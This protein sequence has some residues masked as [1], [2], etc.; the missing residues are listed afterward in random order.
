MN[1]TVGVALEH[2]AALM[3]KAVHPSARSDIDRENMKSVV[4]SSRSSRNRAIT[5]ITRMLNTIFR[6][7]TALI[8]AAFVS[9][10]SCGGIMTF[11]CRSSNN[12]KLIY[13]RKSV[14]FGNVPGRVLEL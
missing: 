4:R 14:A 3:G 11:L 8:I 2:T 10:V 1:C 12:N 6:T 7:M 13:R 5:A 9:L